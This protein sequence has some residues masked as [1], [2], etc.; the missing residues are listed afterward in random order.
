MEAFSDIVIGFSL[1]QLALVLVIPA[2]AIDFVQRPEGIIAFLVT[3]VLIVRFWWLH[4]MIFE[5]YFEPSR[6]MIVCN[7]ATT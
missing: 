1:G 7:F 4:F 2:H 6:L 3:F 5:H